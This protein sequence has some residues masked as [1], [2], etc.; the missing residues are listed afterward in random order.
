ML[1]PNID[2]LRRYLERRY[3]DDNHKIKR[4]IIRGLVEK[5]NNSIPIGSL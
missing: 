5:H 2:L 1:K 3:F 4:T